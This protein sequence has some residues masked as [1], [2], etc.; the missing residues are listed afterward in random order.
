M[1]KLTLPYPKA[2]KNPEKFTYSAF[3]LPYIRKKKVPYKTS[4]IPNTNL[5]LIEVWIT[6]DKVW[7]TLS[8]TNSENIIKYSSKK[9]IL[10]N[11]GV[12]LS[13]GSLNSH[14]RNHCNTT[15]LLC[16]N[17]YPQ[18]SMHSA[19]KAHLC[20]QTGETGAYKAK[21]TCLGIQK[22]SW[23]KETHFTYSQSYPPH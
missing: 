11:R 20:F 3:W 7:S 13:S 9:T 1:I 18:I 14:T 12:R 22:S 6:D 23:K 17:V 15:A 10:K 21:I 19:K 2:N 16:T 5:L 8:A 4:I